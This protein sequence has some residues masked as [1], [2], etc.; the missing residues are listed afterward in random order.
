MS[1]LRRV[2]GSYF[3]LPQCSVGEAHAVDRL[4][5]QHTDSRSDVRSPTTSSDPLL[6]ATGDGIGRMPNLWRAWRRWLGP[7]ELKDVTIRESDFSGCY[8]KRPCETNQM[9]TRKAL[10][11]AHTSAKA[12]QQST[13]FQ[14]SCTQ[15]HTL[16]DIRPLN[17]PD[18]KKIKIHALFPGK[19]VIMCVGKSPISRC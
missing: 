2:R 14:S 7:R 15:L 1:L 6:T 13:S 19:S 8:E 9:E 10:R 12:Q 16:I 18:L 11:R 5:E 17:M 4:D 3:C